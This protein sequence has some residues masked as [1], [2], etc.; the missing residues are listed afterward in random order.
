MYVLW[1]TV[2]ALKY[3]QLSTFSWPNGVHSREVSP[4]DARLHVHCYVY[5]SPYTEIDLWT[6]PA[7]QKSIV[8]TH[9]HLVKRLSHIYLHKLIT[10]NNQHNSMALDVCTWYLST[11]STENREQVSKRRDFHLK[12][13]TFR[14]LTTPLRILCKIIH[15]TYYVPRVMY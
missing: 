5:S 4:Y 10:F 9:V 11:D 6:F 1:C 7:L 12:C 2:Q 3:G 14:I 13:V 15:N 8:Y